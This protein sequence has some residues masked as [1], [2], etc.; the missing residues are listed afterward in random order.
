MLWNK[1]LN[2]HIYNQ[3]C[4]PRELRPKIITLLHDKKLTGHR[5]VHKIY[6]EAIRHF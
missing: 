3:L 1:R 4:I 6:E 5:G 2:K